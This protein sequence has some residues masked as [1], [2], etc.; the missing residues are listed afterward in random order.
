MAH[1]SIGSKLAWIDVDRI[2]VSPADHHWKL[3]LPKSLGRRICLFH[4]LGTIYNSQWVIHSDGEA[5]ET[6][7]DE[8]ES[9]L[10]VVGVGDGRL[11]ERWW[12]GW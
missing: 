3:R 10:L 8:G 2:Y 9:D 7:G 5:C 4:R 12:D 1:I 6:L 11:Q